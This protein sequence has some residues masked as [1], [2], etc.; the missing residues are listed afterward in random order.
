MFFAWF[1]IAAVLVKGIRSSGKASY[2]LALF[3]YVIIGVLLIRAVTLDGAMNGIIYFIKPRWDKILDPDVSVYH[4]IIILILRFCETSLY[5]V[6]GLVCGGDS[7]LLF[8]GC[9]FWKHCHVFV[10]QQ[11]QSQYLS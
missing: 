1:V 3:P 4:P 10:I 5:F 8:I 11:I 6:S 9:W 2:F 7:V